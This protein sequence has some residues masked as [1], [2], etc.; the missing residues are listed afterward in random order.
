ME[1]PTLQHDHAARHM[2]GP[3]NDIEAGPAPSAMAA[4]IDAVP[5]PSSVPG[6]GCPW[7][8]LH[9]APGPWLLLLLLLQ[10]VMD[11]LESELLALKNH[12][13]Q[14]TADRPT[15][16]EQDGHGDHQ[17]QLQRAGC[18]DAVVVQH[19]AHHERGLG[20]CQGVVM[21][22]VHLAVHGCHHLQRGRGR[23]GMGIPACTQ[24]MLA[25]SRVR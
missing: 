15:S 6:P 16:G 20:G 21:F 8:R 12:R 9:W 11:P 3:S 25:C 5:C 4:A 24:M 14:R 22:L 19:V 17:R 7:P 13:Q 10:L 1:A 18:V 2:G 23:G